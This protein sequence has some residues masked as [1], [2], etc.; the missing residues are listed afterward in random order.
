MGQSSHRANVSNITNAFPCVVTTT[1]AHGYETDSFVRLT[2]LNGAV[3]IPRG[4]DPINNYRFK[5]IVTSTTAFSIHDPITGI[6]IDSTN[7]PHYV[8]GGNCNLI[9]TNFVY[10]AE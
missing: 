2:D 10:N 8:T 5:I 3:P 6:G 7:Y 1:A 4:Q 9:E